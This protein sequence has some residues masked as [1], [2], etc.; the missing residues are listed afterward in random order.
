MFDS[1]DQETT[2]SSDSVKHIYS[3]RVKKLIDQASFSSANVIGTVSST[4][5][6]AKIQD[7]ST[8][9]GGN[10]KITCPDE[11][12]NNWSTG[13]FSYNH[14]IEGLDFDMQLKIPHTQFKIY[15]MNGYHY[16]YRENG[17]RM[18]VVWQDYHGNPPDCFFESGTETPLTGDNITFNNVIVREYGKNLMFEP[19]PLEFIHADVDKPQVGIKVNG[20]DGVCPA[21]NCGYL[22]GD[23]T[24]EITS[25]TVSGTTVTVMGTSLPTSNVKVSIAN[26]VCGT[27][28]ASATE[29]TCTLN[30]GAAAG[31]WDIKVS[32]ANGYTPK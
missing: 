15:V 21:F 16:D 4:I 30:A 23:A 11:N 27:V 32:D 25:Q 19:I 10:F 7:S 29:I 8:P 31:S 22:Y 1:S 9:L 14:W 28:T 26:S 18:A 17:L 5:S 12:G 6:I 13:E 3:V 24:G 2:T 20:I